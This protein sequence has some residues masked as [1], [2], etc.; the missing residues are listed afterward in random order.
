MFGLMTSAQLEATQSNNARRQVFYRYPQGAFPLMGLLSLMDDAEELDKQTF[1]WFEYRDTLVGSLMVAASGGA[2]PFT[3]T[4]GANGAAGTALTSGGWTGASQT[5]IRA[6]VV[7]ASQFRVRD[8]IWIKDQPGATSTVVQ[9]RG[10]IDAV[11][12][13]TNSV[14]I[15][16]SATVTNALNSNSTY[17]T[18][19]LSGGNINAQINVIGTASVEG[20]YAKLGGYTF[21]VEPGNYT[22]I[23]RT[24]VGPWSRNA[25]KMGQVFDNSGVYKDDCKQ[26]HIRHMKAM[27]FTCFWGQRGTN[28][29]LDPDDG[30]MKV[31]KTTGGLLYYLG[32]WELG[33]TSNG[34]I[35]NYR[36]NGADITASAWNADDDKR[37][38]KINGTVT[39][40]QFDSIIE[41]IFRYT[42]DGGFEKLVV[43]GSGFLTVFNQFAERNAIKVVSLNESEDTYGMKVTMWDTVY[44]TLYFKQHPLFVQNPIFNWSAFVVDMG[45]I[46]Y[47]PFQDSD[48]MLLT[49]RQA[50]DFDGRKD[51]WLTEYGLEIKFP[52]RHFYIEGLTAI[53]N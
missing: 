14:D 7:D 5:Y 23:M 1:Q 51:E 46:L 21:P 47:H 24:V 19:G 31:E 2:G 44:G 25:L 8:V 11:W 52:E 37:I 40:S 49:N 45:S 53:T 35:A 18:G 13:S 22:Q 42:G 10:V 36:P 17:V 9:I 33:S 16:L 39:K 41:R 28:S 38:L 6:F 4:T 48:T 50:R 12:P 43:C 32:Q 15:R 34:A 20:G 30:V 27:E 29:V 26:A 3:D